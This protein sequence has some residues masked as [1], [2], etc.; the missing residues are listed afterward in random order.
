MLI[1]EIIQTLLSVFPYPHLYSSQFQLIH[2]VLLR[3]RQAH[4]YTR[5]RIIE[6]FYLVCLWRFSCLPDPLLM[7]TLVDAHCV[8][9]VAGL[10]SI[11]QSR[12]RLFHKLSARA[13]GGKH[14]CARVTTQ[15]LLHRQRTY[16]YHSLTQI[17]FLQ[18]IYVLVLPTTE[19]K[20]TA[21][22]G[23]RP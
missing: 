10:A 8:H 17:E 19:T 3:Y 15:A 20:F 6:L 9:Y 2:S 21:S 14:G 5:I 16:V 12:K 23:K 18:D 22:T 4:K 11:S 13:D 1:N 7:W